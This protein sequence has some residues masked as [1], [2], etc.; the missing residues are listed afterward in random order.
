MGR[1]YPGLPRSVVFNV[2][3]NDLDKGLE[4]TLVAFA[5][6][7]K[8]G[9]TVS[10]LKGRAATQRGLGRLEELGIGKP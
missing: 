4:S 9:G 5:D 2:F 6:D 3:M 7:T 10:A 1:A 8:L